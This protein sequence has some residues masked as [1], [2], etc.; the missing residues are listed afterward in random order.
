MGVTASTFPG[1]V[2]S[3]AIVY[4]SVKCDPELGTSET[5]LLLSQEEDT[6]THI[7]DAHYA[8]FPALPFP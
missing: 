2:H 1:Q 4:G 7:W 5:A 6:Y 8:H 3:G